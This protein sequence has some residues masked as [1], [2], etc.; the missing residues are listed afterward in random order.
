MVMDHGRIHFLTDD[1]SSG[2]AS[3]NQLVKPM[4]EQSLSCAIRLYISAPKDAQAEV[5]YFTKVP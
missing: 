5:D 4:S 1:W 2:M 3:M